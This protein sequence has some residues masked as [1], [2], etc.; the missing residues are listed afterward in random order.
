MEF[1][2]PYGW[3]TPQMQYLWRYLQA[4][5]RFEKAYQSGS[6]EN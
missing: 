6:F 5:D 1:S 2:G 4:F 3:T